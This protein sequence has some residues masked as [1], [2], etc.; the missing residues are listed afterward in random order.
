[1]LI[2]FAWEIRRLENSLKKPSKNPFEVNVPAFVAFNCAVT[3]WHLADWTWNATDDDLRKSIAQHFGFTLKSS[4]RENLLAFYNAVSNDCRD[5]YICRL[6]ANGSK[7]M[8]LDRKDPAIKAR[9]EWRPWDG[10]GYSL[11]ITDSEMIFP[12]QKIFNDAFEYWRR[13]LSHFGFIEDSFIDA[14]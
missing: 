8:K 5:V 9:V 2:K 13:T 4:N 7:H 10:I 14:D 12:A 3:G 6:I 11:T 1:M